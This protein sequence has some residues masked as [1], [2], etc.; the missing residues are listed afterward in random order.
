ME[1]CC[2]Q[3]E[4]PNS[5]S[6]NG[7]LDSLDELVFLWEDC[8]PL[9]TQDSLY[10]DN[11]L[12]RL[13]VSRAKRSG[14]FVYVKMGRF[15]FHPNVIYTMIMRVEC[16]EHPGIMQSLVW[17]GSILSKLELKGGWRQVCRPYQ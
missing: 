1:V 4:N 9:N 12:L 5:D 8:Q 6:G 14:R 7:I 13:R 10:S 15:L 17:T 3:G 16:L 2:S 11:K